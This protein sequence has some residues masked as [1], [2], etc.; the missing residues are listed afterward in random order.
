MSRRVLVTGGLGYLG[1][2]V[3]RELAGEAG[4]EVVLTTRDP[5]AAPRLPFPIAG[6][7]A[8]DL[9]APPP[10]GVFEGVTDV[11]HLAAANEITSGDDPE[12]ALD[13]TTTG[14]LRALTAARAAG[15]RRFIYLSTAHVYGAPLAGRITETSLP[16]PGHPYA[17]T[18]RAAEDFVLAARDRG[19]IEG[20][21][22]RLSN[23]FGW[24]VWAGVDR[25]TLVVNDLCRQAVTQRALTLRSSGAQVRDFIGL[26][27]AARAIRHL[28]ELPHDALGDGVFNLG[29]RRTA[30][31]ASMARRVQARAAEVL[32]FS[33]PL[34]VG[35]PSARDGVGADLEYDCAR[36]AATGFTWQ[37]DVDDEIDGTLTLC[38]RAFGGAEG[39]AT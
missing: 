25:W 10:P 31:I 7:V 24:P 39:D 16:R 36:L 1:G 38:Q 15:V 14:T 21:V 32:G 22:V 12:R 30:S 33:P 29:G 9:A 3:A 2:R 37:G 5:S 35:P 17:I 28:L 20:V 8:L 19:Q 34:S 6:V 4:D 23:G 27:D 13:V 11:V 18:H 26:G